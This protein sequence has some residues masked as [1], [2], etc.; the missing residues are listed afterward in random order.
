MQMSSL[1]PVRS[2]TTLPVTDDRY[3]K[4]VS[5]DAKDFVKSCLSVDPS[6]RLTA[7]QAMDHPV[8]AILLQVDRLVLG[9][10]R[11]GLTVAE[12]SCMRARTRPERRV[13]GK[14]PETLEGESAQYEILLYAE[15]DKALIIFMQTAINAVRA[16]TRFRTFAALAHNTSNVSDTG[17]SEAMAANKKHE[18]ISDDE[19]EGD[20]EFH[21]TEDARASV[22]DK[23]GN[24]NASADADADLAKKMDAAKVSS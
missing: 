12:G 2:L 14:L 11:D 24:A 1:Y 8:S 15:L 13:A 4:K 10:Y 6:K 20:D 22:E 5:D 16:G 9:A 17:A 19:E 23:N 7:D 18:L 3:W 21:D